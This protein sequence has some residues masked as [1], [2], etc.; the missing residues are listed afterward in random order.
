MTMPVTGVL[1]TFTMEGN[2]E[3]Q[4]KAS[5]MKMQVLPPHVHGPPPPKVHPLTAG[6][7]VKDSDFG[8][9]PRKPV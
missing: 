9:S 2:T 8:E 6:S 5:D 7:M 4:L 1:P 3:P